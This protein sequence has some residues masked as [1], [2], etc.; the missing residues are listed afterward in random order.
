[1]TKQHTGYVLLI[2]C[3]MAPLFGPFSEL[4]SAIIITLLIAL[5]IKAGQHRRPW[6]P[7]K[8]LGVIFIGYF[9]VLFTAGLIS[10]ASLWQTLDGLSPTS[11][12][13]IL[14]LA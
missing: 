3:M 5:G 1:M 2:L 6:D 10:D 9:T 14:G 12:V 13:L 4:F 8:I 11:P 7:L